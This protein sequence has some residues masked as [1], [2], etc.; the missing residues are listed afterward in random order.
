MATG[1]TFVQPN[2][3]VQSQIPRPI[4]EYVAMAGYLPPGKADVGILAILGGTSAKGLIRGDYFPR[5]A[6][7]TDATCVNP[8]HT[9]AQPPD[10]VH[11]MS[12]RSEEHTS[13]LQSRLHLVCR[14]LL[15]KKKP[16]QQ[17]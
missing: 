9:F 8:E 6:G 16:M 12:D 13:E 10:L 3:K 17:Q 4:A 7:R 15:E 5:W 11:L 1:D 2:I 14:L